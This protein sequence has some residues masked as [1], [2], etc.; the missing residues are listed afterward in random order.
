MSL[1]EQ[2][3]QELRSIIHRELELEGVEITDTTLIRE[4]PGIESMKVLRIIAKIERHFD[5]ELSDDVVFNIGTFAELVHALGEAR[6][7]SAG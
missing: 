6:A 1:T 7:E 2:E 3:M 5:V 4:L